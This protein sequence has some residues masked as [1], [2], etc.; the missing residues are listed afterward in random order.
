MK[1]YDQGLCV[2]VGAIFGF[3]LSLIPLA[4]SHPIKISE[5]CI[6]YNQVI[7]CEVDD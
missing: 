5:E 7:Y 4:V 2:I 3:L 6:S 1:I